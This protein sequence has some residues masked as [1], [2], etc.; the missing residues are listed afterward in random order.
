MWTKSLWQNKNIVYC[1]FC[2]IIR[3]C[4][5]WWWPIYR[6]KH[7]AVKT[8]YVETPLSDVNILKVVFD[9]IL[10]V[11]VMYRN[12]MLIFFACKL[13]RKEW[14]QY[15]GWGKWARKESRPIARGLFLML[16]TEINQAE[17]DSYDTTQAE[18]LKLDSAEGVR[19]SGKLNW[20]MWEEF[21]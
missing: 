15:Y 13:Y 4:T 16:H 17:P 6:P 12:N 1:I 9:C 21:Y 11:F 20:V 19:G 14:E 2:F 8:S 7:V 3:K 18:Y 10:P 5:T